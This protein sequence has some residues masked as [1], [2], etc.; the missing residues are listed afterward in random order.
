MDLCSPNL[1][2]EATTLGLFK[3]GDGEF[4]FTGVF[5]KDWDTKERI[6]SAS[7]RF[8]G[9]KKLLD[10]FAKDGKYMRLHEK[11]YEPR[12]EK[13]SLRGF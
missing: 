8:T 4:S 7:K 9:G 12:C 2:E 11:T 1:I 10:N 13:T 6:E 3:P 5:G